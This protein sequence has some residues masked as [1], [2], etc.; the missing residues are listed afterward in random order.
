M[1]KIE[2]DGEKAATSRKRY[3]V[4][5]SFDG[6]DKGEFFTADGDDWASQH[7]TT[8]YLRELGDAEPGREVP[9]GE[10]G[11]VRPR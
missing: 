11:E 8:G 6:L 2:N 5:V 9:D 7:V 4:V 10:R 1:A 3:E